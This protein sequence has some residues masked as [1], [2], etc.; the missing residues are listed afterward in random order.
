MGKR[1]N[2]FSDSTI[3]LK[4]ATRTYLKICAINLHLHPNFKKHTFK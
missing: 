3:L 1:N 4:I 2:Q